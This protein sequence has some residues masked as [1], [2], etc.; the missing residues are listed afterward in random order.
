VI[1]DKLNGASKS[2]TASQMQSS[3]STTNTI[4][5]FDIVTIPCIMQ[6]SKTTLRSH[7]SA[8]TKLTLYGVAPLFFQ[9]MQ[10][11]DI[12]TRQRVPP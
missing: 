12:G 7:Y 8:E 1:T 2:V 9:A 4:D 6:A 3:S 10:R 11:K 5:S